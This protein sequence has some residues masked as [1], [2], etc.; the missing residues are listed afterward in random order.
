MVAEENNE[1]KKLRN[2][3]IGGKILAGALY[4]VTVF[5][6]LGFLWQ[7]IISFMLL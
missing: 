2:E 1:S 3:R 4:S 6:V 7:S 5:L